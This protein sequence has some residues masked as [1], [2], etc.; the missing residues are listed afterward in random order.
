VAS[1]QAVIAGGEAAWTSEFRFRRTDGTYAPVADRGYVVRDADGRAVRMIG[2]M[3]DLS[4]RRQL[5]A[6]LR[7]AQKLEAVGRLAGGVA[8]EF[9]NLLMVI[10]S[11]AAGL[12]AELPPDDEVRADV[13]AIRRAAD[14]AAEL[15]RQLLAFGRQQILR[16]QLLDASRSVATVAA[17]LWRLLGEDITVQTES[18]PDAALVHAD[19]GQ[20]EEALLL[21]VLN[22]R[23]AMRTGGTLRL[24]TAHVMVDT[25]TAQA[26]PGLAAGRYVSLV[27]EDTGTGIDPVV[28]PRIFEPFFTTKGVGEGT[29]LGLATVYGIV[30]QSGGSI[31]VESTPGVGSRFVVLLPA[32]EAPATPGRTT[33]DMST[34]PA[35]PRGSETILLVDDETA[36]RTAVRRMLERLG[37]T[38]LEA[39][40][41]ERFGEVPAGAG[42]RT[43]DLVLTDII[44]PEMNG[45]ALVE[46][47][48]SCRP[49]PRVLYMSGYPGDDIL[50]RGLLQPGTSVLEKPFTPERLARAVRQALDA[51]ELS[52]SA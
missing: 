36:V 7:E 5:E 13:D 16:P 3:Q 23:D 48:P 41:A 25:A 26:R 24:R 50:R 1:L 42:R 11:Y 14:R 49:R 18:A 45:R 4:E 44:M 32:V 37:Y 33:V 8:H 40:S 46:Q 30:H 52:R 34:V 47:L 51:S 28:L 19:P 27:V 38:V 17:T 15:T 31:S 35:L 6:Q 39:A 10:V 9:N 22:A 2:A 20:L 21:L 12:A 43:V 29:G